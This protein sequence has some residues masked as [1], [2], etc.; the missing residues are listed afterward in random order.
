MQLALA[1]L[2]Q[3][4]PTKINFSKFYYYKWQFF[5]VGAYAN[6]IKNLFMSSICNQAIPNICEA[7]KLTLGNNGLMFLPP[8]EK[9]FDLINI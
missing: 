1:L 6:K 7:K 4:L 5:K 9:T 2:G 3:F 8:L